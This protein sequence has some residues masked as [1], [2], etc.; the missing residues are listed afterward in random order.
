MARP[1]NI[2]LGSDSAVSKAALR[3][4]SAWSV[5]STKPSPRKS[6]ANPPASS[7]REMHDD[8]HQR[9]AIVILKAIHLPEVEV[10]QAI[11][12]IHQ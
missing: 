10:G 4:R 7:I 2:V 8:R 12:R 11:F 9:E 3:L 6:E 5:S 1:P